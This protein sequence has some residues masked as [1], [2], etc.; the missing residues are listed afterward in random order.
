MA[1]VANKTVIKAWK[2]LELLAHGARRPRTLKS[3]TDD[4]K[5]ALSYSEIEGALLAF[6]ELGVVQV[7]NG[8][9]NTTF[10]LLGARHLEL[11]QAEIQGLMADR[12]LLRDVV[13]KSVVLPIFGDI[14]KVCDEVR[15]G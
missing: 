6:A 12:D 1:T 13:T 15:H 11:A 8:D 3:L 4:A 7:L 2:V 5:G 14:L 9:N 10:W